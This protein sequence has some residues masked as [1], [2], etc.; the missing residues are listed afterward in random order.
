M[1]KILVCMKLVLDPEVTFSSFKVD[2][3]AMKP[4]P[5]EGM[6]PVINPF[7]ENALQAALKIKDEQ[8]SMITV[9]SLGRSLPKAILQR[10]LAV[11][12][13]EVIALEG[14]E[15]EHLD[16]YTTAQALA[17]AINKIGEFDL[18]FT[19]RQAADWDNGVVWAGI[20]ESLNLPSVTIARKATVK[21]E[22]AIVER[23]TSEGI[24]MVEVCLPA[25]ITF[26]NEAGEL[27][28]F[29]LPNLI[30][31]KKKPIPKWSGTEVCLEN[32]N[33]MEM[34]DFYIP[35]FR[36]VDCKFITGAS[37]EEKGRNLA[38]KLA[39]EKIILKHI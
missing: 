22:K 21:G 7:D 2:R 36:L 24:E 38:R 35:N 34:R 29:S 3:E 1:V 8:D 6:P 28:N 23:V 33:I 25:L 37:M 19:G 20:A 4:I 27:R 31:V 32:L 9:I 30:K 12:A 17:N 18:I 26:S 5:P 15:F 16:P 10:T 11:G 39:E 14:P 13:D